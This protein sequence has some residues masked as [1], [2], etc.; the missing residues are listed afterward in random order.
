MVI[1]VLQVDA[2]DRVTHMGMRFSGPLPVRTTDVLLALGRPDATTGPTP[3]GRETWQYELRCRARLDFWGAQAEQVTRFRLSLTL[4]GGVRLGP[5]VSLHR[6]SSQ[7][8]G[9]PFTGE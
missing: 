3:S 9:G 8:Q 7:L 1:L 5:R 6:V 2:E 4:E